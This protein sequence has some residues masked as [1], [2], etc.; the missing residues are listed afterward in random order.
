M[1][2]TAQQIAEA[3]FARLWHQYLKRVPYALKYAD[4]VG[5]MGGKVVIDHI[6]LRTFN[7]HTGEQ[8]GGITAISH[9]L[10]LFGYTPAGHYTFAKNQI[11]A[12]HFEVAG[13][14]LPSVFVSQLEVDELP[15]WVQ[16][17]IHSAVK[18][19][20]YLISET[21]IELMQLLK[22]S[23]TLPSEA[24]EL[25]V[26]D[27][28]G[29]FRRPWDVPFL[30]DVLK[31]NDVS[32]Y[33][34]WVL[35]HGNSVNHFAALINAQETPEWPDIEATCKAL[36]KARIPMKDFIEGES[37]SKL[38]QSATHAVKEDV[39]VRG[40][41]G[42]EKITWTY[43][44]FELTERGYVD[45]EEGKKKRFTGFLSGQAKHLFDITRNRET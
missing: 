30:D 44:Y 32:Q 27:L 29:Y 38:R 31:I 43:A 12:I 22:E 34:A 17:M 41:D 11:T 9:I 23:G 6:A 8:P 24:A 40:E 26:E 18:D 1:R 45:D 39:E 2:A 25:L 4:I 28:A 42:I 13:G 5:D 3:L 37:G 16:N 14:Y 19:T 33:A 7:S 10:E 21:A 20:S 35:L 15:E 36:T